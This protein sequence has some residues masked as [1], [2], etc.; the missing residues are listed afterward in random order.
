MGHGNELVKS[1][2]FNLD[3]LCNLSLLLSRDTPVGIVK[4]W[5]ARIQFLV[6]ARTFFSMVS[7]LALRPTEPPIQCVLGG[8]LRGYKVAGALS[9]PLIS[10]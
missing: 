4:G 10:P 8:P 3:I 9:R 5:T 1:V 7:R 6:E 2:K